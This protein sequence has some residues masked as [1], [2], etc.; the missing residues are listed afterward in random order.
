MKI[1]KKTDRLS[2]SAHA[3]HAT[4]RTQSVWNKI[5]PNWWRPDADTMSIV[6]SRTLIHVAW[7]GCSSVSLDFTLS[8]L[9]INISTTTNNQS[10]YHY[11][12]CWTQI[13]AI[14][15]DW[16]LCWSLLPD[17]L[18]ISFQHLLQFSLFTFS[19]LSVSV[20]FADDNLRLATSCKSS[21]L[22]SSSIHL[23]TYYCFP[24]GSHIQ[25]PRVVEYVVDIQVPTKTSKYSGTYHTFPIFRYLTQL[26]NITFD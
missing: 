17:S 23:P 20:S 15:S 8:T 25:V 1:A 22:A 18:H 11:V 19:H 16:A 24:V 5:R 9:A 3:C 10:G 12:F 26:P 13:S 4:C 6:F 14:L 2:H 21:W 7:C